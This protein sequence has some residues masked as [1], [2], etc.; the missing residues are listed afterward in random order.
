MNLVTTLT[1]GC[2]VEGPFPLV[3][4]SACVKYEGLTEAQYVEL[5]G[6]LIDAE[7]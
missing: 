1:G 4:G 6:Y 3:C 2:G 7:A 5:A